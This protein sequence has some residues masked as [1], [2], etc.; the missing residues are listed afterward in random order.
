MGALRP[1]LS[2][3]AALVLLSSVVATVSHARPCSSDMVAVE[4]FC[5]D[6][7][8]ASLVDASTGRL[9]SPHYPPSRR[10]LL[11]VY[12]AWT[13]ERPFVGDEDARMMP[14]PEPPEWQKREPFTP[15]AVSRRG[16]VPQAFVSSHMARAACERAGKRL[17]THDEWVTACRGRKNRKFPYGDT[18]DRAQCNV[19]GYIHP[20]YVLHGNSSAGH[21]D[22]RLNLLAIDGKRPLLRRTGT[23]ESCA[24]HWGDDAIYDMVGNVDEWVDDPQ[25]R[26]VGGFYARSTTSGCEAQ[27]ANHSPAYYDY[28]TGFRCCKDP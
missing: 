16:S 27:V 23:T 25:G 26:F 14:L 24:S 20:A 6:R 19:Y 4:E 8:E 11:E 22:P 7:F 5:I 21:R 15:K 18:F 3:L 10:L 2:S 17:C 1:L 13:L 12:R 28:S 9:L